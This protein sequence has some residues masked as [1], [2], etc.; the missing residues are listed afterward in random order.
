MRATPSLHFWPSQKRQVVMSQPILL[1]VPAKILGCRWE[2]GGQS[3]CCRL[4]GGVVYSGGGE[5][6][7]GGGGGEMREVEEVE[8]KDVGDEVER[9]VE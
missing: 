5:C 8:G 1:G 9:V 4:V 7:I 3:P 2:R 6:V